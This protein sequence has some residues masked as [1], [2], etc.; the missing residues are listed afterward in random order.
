MTINLLFRTVSNPDLG[1]WIF[2]VDPQTDTFDA[3]DYAEAYN[4]NVNEIDVETIKCVSDAVNNNY[5]GTRWIEV[6][7]E[8]E[9]K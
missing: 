7:H 6:T 8:L 1:G 4:I 2:S 3:H 5:G 9:G